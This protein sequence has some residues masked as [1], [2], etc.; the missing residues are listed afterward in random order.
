MK[1]KILCSTLLATV[2]FSGTAVSV[3][4]A[5]GDPMKTNGKVEVTDG[6]IDPGD[7]VTDP[8][9]PEDKLPNLPEIKPNPNPDMGPLEISHAPELDFGKVKTATK[10]VRAYAKANTFTDSTGAEQTRGPI[11]QFGDLRTAQDGYEVSAKMTKQ[12]TQTTG[13]G[14]LTGST[15]TLTNPYAD[16]AANSTGTKPTFESTVTLE[17]NQSVKL[18][19]AD[20]TKAKEGKG[21]WAVEYGSSK[22]VATDD[23]TANSVEL[24]IPANTA[25]SMAGGNYLADIEWSIKAAP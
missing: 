7:G 15:I 1:R 25:S 22:N 13:T 19:S 14:E 11:L 18:A 20:K 8:E 3:G 10:D 2:A 4:A 23:T 6:V 5:S 16:T 24:L 12:F 17:Y 9:K 21:M